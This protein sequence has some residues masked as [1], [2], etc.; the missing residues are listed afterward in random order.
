[1]PAPNNRTKITLNDVVYGP[2]ECIPTFGPVL[3]GCLS[4]ALVF[5]I[6]RLISVVYHLFQYWEMRSF[7]QTALHISKMLI[8][9]L[10]VNN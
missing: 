1:M 6:L 2:G 5:W 10:C 4:V 3:W 8:Y 9:F 7:Y